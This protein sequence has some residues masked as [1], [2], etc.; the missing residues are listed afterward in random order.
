MITEEV[1]IEQCAPTLSSIKT[2]SLFTVK[3]TNCIQFYASL[4][5]WNE[6]IH[7]KGLK[8]IVLRK[9]PNFYLLYLYREKQLIKDLQDSTAKNIMK[10][11][12]YDCTDLPS[13]FAKLK[14]RFTTY[15]E[16]PHEIGLFLSF[17]PED[18]EGFIC[19]KGRNCK[20][21]G[22][23]KVYGNTEQALIQFAKYD[24]CRYI[25]RKL[26]NQGIDVLRLT[27]A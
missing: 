20:L 21:C 26:W 23:W 22:Y 3:V 14:Q 24:K 27:V 7:D 12:N 15:E 13:V 19:N 4:S 25:Y 8:M 17:P 5:E 18:V 11:Y 2:G 1:L 10:L 9:C 16:F 6:K